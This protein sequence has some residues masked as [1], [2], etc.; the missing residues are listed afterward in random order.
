MRIGEHS[1]HFAEADMFKQVALPLTFVAAF[2][3]A[4]LAVTDTAQA[5]GRY[6]GRPYVNF[7]YGPPN[8]YYYGGY[9]V[10]QPYRSYYY[11]PRV[12]R[13]Y[14]ANYYGPGVYYGPV[15]R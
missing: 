2:S 14:T 7:Y 4:G 13:P 1:K 15:Y 8:A 6:Y 5:W 10:Y 12:V 3:V 11:G 9:P